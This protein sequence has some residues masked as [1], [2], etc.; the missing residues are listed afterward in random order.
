[1]NTQKDLE[2]G[3]ALIDAVNAGDLSIWE[4]VLDEEFTCS[5]PG[6]REG[7]NRETAK[8]FNAGI[9][10]GFPDLHF[11]VQ[12]TIANGDTFV[13]QYMATATHTGPL[14]LPTG[15]VPATGRKGGL[16]GVFITVVKDGKIVREESYW[17]QLELLAQLGLMG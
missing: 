10:V 17:N 8:A 9:M 16:P 11:D 13:Y 1:M 15:T 4:A 5:Y 14:E 7:G 12:R 6:L 2:I 3:R